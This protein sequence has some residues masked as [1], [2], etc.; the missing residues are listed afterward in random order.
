MLEQ[1]RQRMG[2]DRG[3]GVLYLVWGET[4][5]Q[6]VKRSIESLERFELEHCVRELDSASKLP[7]KSGMYELSPFHETLFLDSDTVVIEDPAFG[8]EMAAR[9]GLAL[10]IEPDCWARR[11]WAQNA[12]KRVTKDIP[13]Y[14]TGVLF[15]IKHPKTRQLFERWN[16]IS[17]D[18]GEKNDQWSFSQ[19]VYDTGSNPFILP[20]NW[21]F[22]DSMLYGPLKIW[23]VRGIPPPCNTEHWNRKPMC[24]G[25]VEDGKIIPVAWPGG[26]EST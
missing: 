7:A 3:R 17:G 23:H 15:Y 20:Q 6:E 5:R 10:S 21:N 13:E 22:R 25:R 24:L 8:F 19:A 2:N 18:Y 1:R 9:H 26:R 11:Q 12:P 16:E 14:N 4:S